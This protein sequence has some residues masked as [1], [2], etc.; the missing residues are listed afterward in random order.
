[1]HEVLWTVAGRRR[2]RGASISF[3]LKAPA[4]EKQRSYDLPGR[5]ERLEA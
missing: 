5:G 2:Y 3:L 1:L 4:R